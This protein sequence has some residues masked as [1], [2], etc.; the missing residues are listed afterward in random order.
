MEEAWRNS[1]LKPE[2][3]SII[4]SFGILKKGAMKVREIPHS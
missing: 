3:S 1:E 2:R 4:G